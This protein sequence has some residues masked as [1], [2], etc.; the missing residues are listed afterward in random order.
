V[1]DAR[2]QTEL[3]GLHQACQEARTAT[4]EELD[5]YVSFATPDE[6]GGASVMDQEAIMR[7]SALIETERKAKS[8]YFDFL[9]LIARS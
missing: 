2:T 7:A 9:K 5:K 3:L 1:D 4:A 8:A 6:P